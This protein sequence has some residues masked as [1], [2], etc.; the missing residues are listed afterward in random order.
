MDDQTQ[1]AAAANDLFGKSGQNLLP[2]LNQTNEETQ[3]LIDTTSELGLIMSEDSIEAS[4]KFKDTQDTIQQALD[5]TTRSL[6][7]Q[8]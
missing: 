8:P 4:V 2:L 3:E 6:G 5:A 1:K 7:E